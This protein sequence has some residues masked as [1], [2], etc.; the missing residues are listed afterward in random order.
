MAT[1]NAAWM[2]LPKNSQ[3]PTE[4]DDSVRAVKS[5]VERR[6]RNEH[7]T[8]SDATGGTQAAD[9]RHKE[10]SARAWFEDAEPANAPSTGA[11]A[12][13]H[14]WVDS[15]NQNVLRVYDDVAVAFEPIG[16]VVA[17]VD[18][19]PGS[20]VAGQMWLRTDLV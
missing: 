2:L 9:W 15:N 11:L 16:V 14:L 6:I 8:F 18:A 10:G 17:A 7:D 20:P 1:W 19:D 4:A 12:S 5:E 3:S 13:G